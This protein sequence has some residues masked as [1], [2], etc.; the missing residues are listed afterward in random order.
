MFSIGVDFL[1]LLEFYLC[2]VVNIPSM[3]GLMIC[4]SIAQKV[5]LMRGVFLSNQILGV[6][7]FSVSKFS[8]V[9]E[10]QTYICPSDGSLVLH[11]VLFYLFLFKFKFP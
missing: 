11:Y 4:L 1:V 6:L 8:L 5:I 3:W 2:R 10:C 7:V 9:F